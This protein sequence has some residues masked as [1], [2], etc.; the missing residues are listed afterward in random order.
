MGTGLGL[1]IAKQ[2]AERMG[3]S[4][5]LESELQVGT[6]VEITLPFTIDTAIHLPLPDREEKTEWKLA[7]FR[8]LLAED[9]D[10][11]L[12]IA[13]FLLENVGME[14]TAARNGQEAVD[15]FAS[16]APQHY[17]LILMDIMMPKMDGLE[18]TRTIRALDR[19]DAKTIPIFAMTANAFPDDVVLSK[20][21]GMNEHIS[22][23]LEGDELLEMIQKYL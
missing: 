3:G 18:A 10:L 19:P 9:N 2:L 17:A 12:E 16:S 1:S 5:R 7:G 11:N 15:L 21:A 6:K 22:K 8:V 13:Q 4:I 14:V 23:P 20:Q